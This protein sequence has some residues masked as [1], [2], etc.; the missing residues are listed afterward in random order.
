MLSN[1]DDLQT[2]ARAKEE[3]V[4]GRRMLAVVSPD[5]DSSTEC[6]GLGILGTNML[7]M[8]VKLADVDNVIIADQ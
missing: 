7:S 5:T 2:Q 1:L 4:A 3:S 6:E 8:L